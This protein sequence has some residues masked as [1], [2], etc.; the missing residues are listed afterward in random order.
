MRHFS[1]QNRARDSLITASVT[2][3]RIRPRDIEIEIDQFLV[4]LRQAVYR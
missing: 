3:L 4:K 1:V 2:A